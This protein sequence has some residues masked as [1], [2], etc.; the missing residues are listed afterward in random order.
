MLAEG[1]EEEKTQEVQH[2][3]DILAILSPEG[4][5]VGLGKGLKARGNVED[6]LGKVE[7]AMFT[8]LRKLTKHALADY[9]ER[10]R[11][12]WILCHC[13]QVVLTVSQMM[14]CRDVTEI[15]EAD[16]NH[17]E[18]LKLF[19]EDCF[20]DLNNLAALVRGELSKLAR[21]VLCALITIDV[22]ARDMVTAM[23]NDGVSGRAHKNKFKTPFQLCVAETGSE[24]SCPADFRWTTK[25][26]STG[27]NK[28]GTTGTMTWITVL[29][30]CPAHSTSTDTNTLE[31]H[32]DWS[33]RH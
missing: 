26:T 19:E 29:Y 30:A 27:R 7:D 3:N 10:P 20:K 5:K 24:M 15:L 25:R 13:S 6:W 21:A 17:T 33:S 1:V 23:V 4:E 31:L 12:E 16:S 22:H 28:R 18:N 14:W 2:T 8:N 32:P 9:E 11:E